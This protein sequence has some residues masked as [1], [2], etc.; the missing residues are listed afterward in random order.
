MTSARRPAVLLAAT[1]LALLPARAAAQPTPA[2]TRATSPSTSE[3]ATV[4]SPLD[5][6]RMQFRKGLDLTTAGR[7]DDALTAFQ[8]AYD[9]SPTYRILYNIGQ[10]SRHVG[11]PARSL[12]AFERYLQEGGSDIDP[13]RH[14]EVTTEIASLRAQVASARIHAPP[15]ASLSLDG[16]PAGTAP[17]R[18][19]LYLNPGAHRLRAEQPGHVPTERSMDATAG[20][21]LDLTLTLPLAPSRPVPPTSP[22]RP[23]GPPERRASLWIGWLTTGALATAATVTG[24]LAAVTAA[25]FEDASYAGPNRLP[26][27]DSEVS[28]LGA[29]VDALSITTDILLAATAASFGVTLALHLTS[30]SPDASRPPRAARL[31][32]GAGPA[33][34]WLTGAF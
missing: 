9:L 6:A 34:A 1:A 3:P 10:V 13:A 2:P 28:A 30:P 29:R 27:P 11:D 23:T 18:D 17:L 21:S 19:P 8:R 25:R 33:G 24:V 15:G 5:Q 32:L 26:P 14:A 20:Q 31:S 4:D 16:L 12:R 7:F 22:P